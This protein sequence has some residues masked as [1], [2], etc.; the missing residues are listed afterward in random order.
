MDKRKID[1]QSGII[2]A[3]KS[4]LEVRKD[5]ITDIGQ[6]VIECVSDAEK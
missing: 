1:N 5:L 2:I 3:E 4:D 6:K